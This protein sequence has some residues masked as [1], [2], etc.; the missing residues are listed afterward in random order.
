MGEEIRVR[1]FQSVDLNQT[2][3]N[4]NINTSTNF[5][6]EKLAQKGLKSAY[7]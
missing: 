3:K 7:N 6:L 5:A 4:V 1:G 2:S